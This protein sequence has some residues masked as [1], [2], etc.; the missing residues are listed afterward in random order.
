ITSLLVGTEYAKALS[1]ASGKKLVPVNHMHGHLYSAFLKD[2]KLR[3]PSI[4]LIVSGG[5]TYIV[6]LQNEKKMKLLGQTVDDAV[7]E[8]F[9][10]VARMLGLPY[11]GGPEISKL[12]AKGK[13]DYQFPRPMLN[14]KNYDFSF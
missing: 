3:M 13:K 6:L 10:K 9:D 11:P 7:G 14:A 8:A 4:N 2:P 1:L 12:A 5:H